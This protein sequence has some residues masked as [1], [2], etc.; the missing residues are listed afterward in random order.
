MNSRHFVGKKRL[1]EWETI[2]HIVRREVE[3]LEY[4]GD[5]DGAKNVLEKLPQED[6]LV[7][8]KWGDVLFK[9]AQMNMDFETAKKALTKAQLAEEAFPQAKYKHTAKQLQDSMKKWIEQNSIP[10]NPTSQ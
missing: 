9:E 4:S 10:P 8:K 3:P 1:V 7:L 2:V 5:I 6:G